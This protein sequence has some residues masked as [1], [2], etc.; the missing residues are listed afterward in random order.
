M[1]KKTQPIIDDVNITSMSFKCVNIGNVRIDQ[2]LRN[3]VKF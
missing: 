3:I 2:F 1:S